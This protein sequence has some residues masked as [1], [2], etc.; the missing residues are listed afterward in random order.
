[1]M[2]FE[3][4]HLIAAVLGVSFPVIALIKPLWTLSSKLTS[5]TKEVEGLI[6]DNAERKSDLKEMQRW[7][8][9]HEREDSEGHEKI[10]RE[11]TDMKIEMCARMSALETHMAAFENRLGGKEKT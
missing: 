3:S 9:H 6:S 8:G 5:L 10:I 11:I 7:R 1:M 4:G 2:D